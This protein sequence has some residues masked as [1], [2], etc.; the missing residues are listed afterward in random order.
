MRKSRTITFFVCPQYDLPSPPAVWPQLGG[1]PGHGGAWP[2]EIAPPVAVRWAGSVGGAILH[3][4]PAVADGAVF[5]T[6]T[7]LADGRTGG[8][9]AF[10]LA[11]GAVRWRAPATAPTRGG[12]A[13]ADGVVAIA[14]LDGTVLGLDAITGETRWRYE[15]GAGLAPEAATVFAAP[16][17]DGGDFLVG[18]QRHFAVLDAATGGRRWTADPVPNGENTQSLAAV[19]VGRG[20]VV[21][22][23][24]RELGGIIAWDRF[25][26]EELWRRTG[27][28]AV[29][30]NASPV[31]DGDTV[32]VVNG[33]TEVLAL[34]VW[35]GAERWL[36]KLD[37]TGF[38]WGYATV[39]APAISAGVLVVPT[40]YR[41][42]VALDATT[43]A[44]LWRHTAAPNPLRTTHYRGA[45]EAGFASSPVITGDVVWAADTSGRLVALELL[46][47]DMIWETQLD[48]PVLAGLAIAGNQLVVASFDGSVRVLGPAFSPPPLLQLECGVP[49]TAG[50]CN[51]ADGAGAIAPGL[52]ALACLWRRR[53]RS[54]AAAAR[55]CARPRGRRGRAAA[56]P[57][58]A[59]ST[60]RRPTP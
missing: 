49:A 11:T 10:E 2:H 40:L 60:R 17:A 20:V 57:R 16:A 5:A 6:S 9:V 35:T 34:D 13:Y 25:T 47:G 15:L 18:N 39:G 38:D 50:C 54:R 1:G 22:V 44:E 29:A 24:H 58:R 33:L 46:T 19:A 37:P 7:D 31:I 30:I 41:D 45:R 32:Y 42:L 48:T 53:R 3:A 21:G 8:V 27:E 14:Q 36:V 43:G 51:A 28:Q 55:P 26:G 59:P 56:R 52:A 4:A 12:P 23:F